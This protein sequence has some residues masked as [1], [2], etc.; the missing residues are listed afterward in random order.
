MLAMALCHEHCLLRVVVG[1]SPI[2][3]TRRMGIA[4]LCVLIVVYCGRY[5]ARVSLSVPVGT[6]VLLP[7]QQEGADPQWLAGGRLHHMWGPT[8]TIPPIY[9]NGTPTPEEPEWSVRSRLEAEGQLPT[10]R[11]SA[12]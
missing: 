4:V 2:A 3:E 1:A 6:L 10:H 9:S 8:R 12:H 11:A 5:E 7:P